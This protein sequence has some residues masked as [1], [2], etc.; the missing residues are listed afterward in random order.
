MSLDDQS[1]RSDWSYFIQ[2]A[3]KET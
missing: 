1:L 2:S 3:L